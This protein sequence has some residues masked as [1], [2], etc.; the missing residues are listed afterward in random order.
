MVPGFLVIG[1]SLSFRADNVRGERDQD[2]IPDAE[3]TYDFIDAETRESITA[4]D[5][6]LYDEATASFDAVISPALTALYD[7]ET[8]PDGLVPN[9]E[10]ALRVTVDN[11]GI[12]TTES[13]VMVALLDPPEQE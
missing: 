2:F 12:T 1:D 3:L 10:Y 13:R 5:M 11:G 7:A 4:G 6:T 8:N 9:R